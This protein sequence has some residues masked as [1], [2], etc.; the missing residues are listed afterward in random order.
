MADLHGRRLLLHE[1]QGGEGCLLVLIQDSL[2]KSRLIVNVDWH[3]SVL[4]TV[5]LTRQ[6]RRLHALMECRQ[7][8]RGPHAP[9]CFAVRAI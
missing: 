2:G 5:L 1:Q 4:P 8:C 3:S 7:I 6:G 9:C